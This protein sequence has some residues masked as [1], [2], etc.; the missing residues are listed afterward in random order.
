[1]GR[2]GRQAGAVRGS[3]STN[4]G[5]SWTIQVVRTCSTVLCIEFLVFRERRRQKEGKRKRKKETKV[6]ER[7]LSI[8]QVKQLPAGQC[9]GFQSYFMP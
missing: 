8:V 7:M 5:G 6:Q 1:V 2:G 9:P 3:T 4:L